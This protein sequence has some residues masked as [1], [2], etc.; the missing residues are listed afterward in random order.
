MKLRAV[1]PLAF[2]TLVVAACGGSEKPATS[3]TPAASTSASTASDDGCI[4]GVMVSET[5]SAGCANPGGDVACPQGLASWF[6]REIVL[7]PE[8]RR[9]VAKCIAAEKQAG[10]AVPA[11]FSLTWTYGYD[12]G[13]FFAH[14]DKASEALDSCVADALAESSN[15]RL[16]RH[17]RNV[18]VVHPEVDIGFTVASDVKI[19]GGK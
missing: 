8:D 16:M 4:D 10:H 9:A 2:A 14:A 3:P 19:C 18:H 13:R 7:H 12:D 1:V 17:F 11:A 5:K 6:R 15:D